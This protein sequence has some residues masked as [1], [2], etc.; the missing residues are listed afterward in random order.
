MSL[1]RSVRIL[2]D[3]NGEILNS[4]SYDPFG[5]LLHKTERIHN[6]F[7]YLGSLGIIKEDELMDMYSMRDRVYD[8]S[9]G[10]FVSVDPLGKSVTDMMCI[11]SLY[12]HII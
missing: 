7:Q 8:A 9:H 3:Q 1:S 2:V 11:K 10:R 5:K 12:I 6:I 4:Y